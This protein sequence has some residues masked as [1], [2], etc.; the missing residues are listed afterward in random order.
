MLVMI[1]P[2]LIANDLSLEVAKL[3]LIA[4]LIDVPSGKRASWVGAV[5]AA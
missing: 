4:A 1:R 3:N 2:T 5:G